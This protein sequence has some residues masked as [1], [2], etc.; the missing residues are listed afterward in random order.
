MPR[1]EGAA[2][3]YEL[4]YE[5]IA[6]LKPAL[7][8]IKA[9]CQYMGGVSRAKFYADVLPMLETVKFGTRNLVVVASM[10]R[11]IEFKRSLGVRK[12]EGSPGGE[13]DVG[14]ALPRMIEPAK[15]AQTTSRQRPKS[16]SRRIC[17]AD[18][19]GVANETRP[20]EPGGISAQ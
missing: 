4:P 14:P 10:D 9:A 11:L 1:I 17:F 2:G 20:N 13:C 18:A 19:A 6:L 15:V 12:S 8:S 16:Q 3:A 7:A 5:P